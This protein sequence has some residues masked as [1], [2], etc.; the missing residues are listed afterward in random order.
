MWTNISENG[1]RQRENS[2][3]STQWGWQRLDQE[4]NMA[5]PPTTAA[6]KKYQPTTSKH[7]AIHIRSCF[8]IYT[9]K[10]LRWSLFLIKFQVFSQQLYQKRTPTEVFSCEINKNT[11]FVEHLRKTASG[12]A[13]DF[14]KN[15]PSS[16]S[17]WYDI[18]KAYFKK[19]F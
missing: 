1:S 17:L 6:S 14:T 4:F 2:F 12:R 5:A 3:S 19:S 11:F 10:D 9:R 8:E 18:S 15:G 7:Q 16:N 13:Q